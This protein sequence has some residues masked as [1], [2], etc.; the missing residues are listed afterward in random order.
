[1]G[2]KIKRYCRACE[3]ITETHFPK[4]ISDKHIEKKCPNCSSFNCHI[5]ERTDY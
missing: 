4:R 3:K 1:M 5:T 2:Y